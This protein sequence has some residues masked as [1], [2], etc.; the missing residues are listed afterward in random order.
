MADKKMWAI[1]GTHPTWF[2]RMTAEA[3]LTQEEAWEVERRLTAMGYQ[4]VWAMDLQMSKPM[5]FDEVVEW[6]GRHR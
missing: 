2:T 6:F 5:L 1:Y 3:L 4:E